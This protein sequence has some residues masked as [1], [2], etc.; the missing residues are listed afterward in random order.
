[1]SSSLRERKLRWLWVALATYLACV[2]P[3]L[4]YATSVPHWVFVLASVSNIVILVTF[5]LS[6]RAVWLSTRTQASCAD[7]D[8][9]EISFNSRRELDRRRLRWLWVGAVIFIVTSLNA[10]L[11][12]DQIPYGLSL[13]IATFSGGIAAVFIL[14]IRRVWKRVRR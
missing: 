1:M 3:A 14:E 13:G 5:V 4:Y 9:S 10:A 8:Q 7:I 2:T 12:R 11:G 6:I